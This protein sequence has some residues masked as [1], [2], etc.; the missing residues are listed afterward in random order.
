MLIPIEN[1]TVL[2]PMKAVVDE[3]GHMFPRG[4][5][6]EVCTDTAAELS[7]APYTGSFAMLDGPQSGAAITAVGC[8]GADGR[9]C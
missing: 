5:P 6:I 3:E 1:Q 2:G 8:V 7:A 9:C 4:T